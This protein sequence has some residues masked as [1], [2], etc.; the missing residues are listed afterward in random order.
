M[1]IVLTVRGHLTQNTP[2][3]PYE[4]DYNLILVPILPDHDNQIQMLKST[5]I[6]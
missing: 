3:S 2:L 5:P 4:Y 1:Q 6:Y